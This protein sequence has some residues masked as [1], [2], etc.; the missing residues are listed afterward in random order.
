MTLDVL[1]V[2][3]G[4]VAG[5]GAA[6]VVWLLIERGRLQSDAAG[7]RA[8]RDGARAEAEQAREELRRALGALEDARGTAA[9]LRE[10]RAQL[11]E[12]SQGDREGYEA[13]ISR[14]EEV[15]RERLE[16]AERVHRERLEATRQAK[17]AIERTLAQVE[18]KFQ[19]V[20]GSLAADALK[21][22][23]S[24][25][26]KLAEQS[27]EVKSKAAEG[28]LEKRRSAVEQL[29]QPITETLRKTDEKLAAMEKERVSAY[30]GMLREVQQVAAASAELRAETGR[31]AQAMRDPQVRGRYGEMQLKRVA[32][33]AGMVEHCDF[34]EQDQTVDDA[35]SALRPDML[36]KMPS[37][38]ELAVDAKTNIRGYLE[39]LDARTPEEAEA[40]LERFAKNIGDQASALGKKNYWSR[41]E[42]SPEFVVMFVPGEQFLDAAMRRRPALL[43]EAASQRVIIASPASLIG[44]LRAVAVGWREQRIEEQAREL[45]ELGRQ[46]H[47]RASVLADHMEKVG[48]ALDQA[49]RRYNDMRGSYES[50]LEPTL[51]RFEEAGAKSSKELTQ[52]AEITVRPRLPRGVGADGEA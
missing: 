26:L 33:L 45:F 36:V 13:E 25:F 43:E 1:H 42:G 44:L 37:G 48:L 50:R 35:G 18:E 21:A 20:F 5:V 15:A 23:T 8:E 10:E 29:V 24:E 16:A 27:F 31:L 28:E 4:V 51:R 46:L 34:V 9:A 11:V 47:E 6:G 38:R 19:K 30:S 22:S 12:R 3:L 2:V 32:E 39:A 41:Y 40:C 52:P 14:V 17:E 7:A 49:V